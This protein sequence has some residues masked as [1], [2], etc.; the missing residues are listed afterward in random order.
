MIERKERNNGI[1]FLRILAMIAVVTLHVL[2]FGG[3][4][5]NAV[6]LTSNYE[7]AW[8]LETVC[9]CAVDVYVLITGFVYAGRKTSGAKLLVL[10]LTVLF[11]S[12]LIPIVLYI[13]GY[14]I[15][16]VIL[17]SSFFPIMRRRYWFFN[18][19]FALF[20]F[21]PTCNVIA[22]RKETLIKTLLIAF[23]LFSVASTLSVDIDLFH[24]NGGSSFL[25]F[26]NLYL[27]GAYIRI[28][29]LPKWLSV[30]N[31][32]IVFLVCILLMFGVNN[33][34]LLVSNRILGR[35]LTW[36]FYSY[37][38]PLFYI[39]AICVVAV[40]SRL[41]IKSDSTKRVIQFVSPLTFGV[42]LI[43]ENPQFRQFF[44]KDAFLPYLDKPAWLML[45][46]VLGTVLVIFIL[47]CLIDCFRVC[48]FKKLKIGTIAERITEKLS[49]VTK[50]IGV[51]M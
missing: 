10:W 43:H 46:C 32:A 25:W 26:L 35:Y 7:V 18:A 12:A 39:G 24:T 38:S 1:D 3:L 51:K 37:A 20:L 29:G 48:V 45:C 13:I 19:Y 31:A 49:C 8:F 4:L 34:I 14:A 50:S 23:V 30:K 2:N 44:I 5:N 6:P 42:Y 17:I 36:I 28:Y 9:Y 15:P 41:E 27:C 33:L 22:N 40:F 47:C 16:K 21:I 11:Y